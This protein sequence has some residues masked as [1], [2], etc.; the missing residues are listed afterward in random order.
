MP[1]NKLEKL[2]ALLEDACIKYSQV[3]TEWQTYNSARVLTRAKLTR[4][5]L[6]TPS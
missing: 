1:K 4:A 5:S 3:G 2:L 6:N